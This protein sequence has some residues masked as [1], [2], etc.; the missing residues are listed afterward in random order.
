MGSIP[1]HTFRPSLSSGL[2]RKQSESLAPHLWTD[3]FGAFD[4]SLAVT[5][6][7][8]KDFSGN[9]NDFDLSGI[10]APGDW[11]PDIKGHS[12]E[13]NGS[14]EFGSASVN[15]GTASKVLTISWSM[16]WAYADDNKIF[17]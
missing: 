12:V 5:G 7:V 13:L 2:A 8:L 14:D 9:A 1:R 11:P 4:P 16:K 17:M 15:F 6:A 3:L 10:V